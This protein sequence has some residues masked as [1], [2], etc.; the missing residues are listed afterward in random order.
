MPVAGEQAF[1]Q[2]V[3]IAI[4]GKFHLA[5][6]QGGG[7]VEDG[8][9]GDFGLPVVALFGQIGQAAAG[10]PQGQGMIGED[11][12]EAGIATDQLAQALA[13]LPGGAAVEGEHQDAARCLAQHPHQVGDAMDDDAGLARAGAGQD[14]AIGVRLFRNQTLLQRV[15]QAVDDAP[16]GFLG[17][18]SFEDFLAAGEIAADEFDFWQREVGEHEVERLGKLLQA[19]LGVFVD[20]V[21]LEVLLVVMLFQR[22]EI[23]SGKATPFLLRV[24][25]DSHRRTEDRLA[26]IEDQR[27]VVVQVK[28]AGVDG[29]QLILQLRAD[30]EIGFQGSGQL[31]DF[32]FHT[33]VDAANFVVE[34]GEQGV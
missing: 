11:G 2:G 7:L 4:G 18:C 5:L 17:G 23:G 20:D 31:A 28:Q 25:L 24:N 8:F 30:F 33:Q 22:L 9:E 19:E 16:V 32:A 13:Y 29:S 34:P 14:Q 10:Q 26:A 12:N 3:A 15:A 21:N 6:Q 27:A 1:A